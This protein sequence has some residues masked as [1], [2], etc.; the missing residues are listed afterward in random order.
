MDNEK[1]HIISAIVE[2][3]AGV[4]SNF[5]NL[6]RRRRFNIESLSVGPIR[7]GDLA[8]ITVTVKANDKVIEQ[9]VKQ[10]NKL[11]DV[12]KVSRLDPENMVSREMILIKVFTKNTTDRS[13]IINYADVFRG[14]IVDVSPDT[15]L[16]EITGRSEKIDAFI[17]L[18]R[19]FGIKEIARTGVTALS[20]ETKP[21]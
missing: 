1:S 20:R 3:K 16:V 15:L 6:F 7:K 10:L 21:K 5:T 17:D 19:T 4:L 9:I 18:M 11:V 14:Q 12:I 8:R 2:H 13:S